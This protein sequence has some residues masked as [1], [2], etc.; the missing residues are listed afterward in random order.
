[1]AG[2]PS[3]YET[4]VKPK[5]HLIEGWARNGL[6]LEQIASN[7]GISVPSLIKYREQH[8]ELFEALKSGKDEADIEVENALYKAATGYYYE[9]ETVTPSG[10]KVTVRRYE[11]PNTTAMIF[12]LKNRKREVWRDK[13]DIEHTGENGGPMQIVWSGGM[14]RPK[15]EGE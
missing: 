9:E 5:L 12:W 6:T 4:D 1:M 3:K 11:K 14:P 10:R 7:L 2:R 15:R 8:V 13:Q